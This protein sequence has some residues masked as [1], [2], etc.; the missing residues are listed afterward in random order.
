[1]DVIFCFFK[2]DSTK[3]KQEKLSNS[4]NDNDIK[5]IQHDTSEKASKHSCIKPKKH[6]VVT[7][8][9]V[10]KSVC[11]VMV[12]SAL[13]LNS[14]LNG[15][16]LVHIEYLLH[17]DTQ[18][19]GFAYMTENIGYILGSITCG[20]VMQYC[21]PE[22]LLGFMSLWVAVGIAGLPWAPNVI[23]FGTILVIK[24]VAYG[25]IDSGG[26]AYMLQLWQGHKYQD[27]VFNSFQCTWTLGAFLSPLIVLPFLSDLPHQEVYQNSSALWNNTLT[28]NQTDALS[29]SSSYKE[30][31]VTTHHQLT[32]V[33]YAYITVATLNF[34]PFLLF[35]IVFC[36]DKSGLNHKPNTPGYH[37]TSQKDRNEENPH[38]LNSSNESSQSL[39]QNHQQQQHQKQN[40]RKRLQIVIMTLLAFIILFETWMNYNFNTF[41]SAFVITRLQWDTAKGPLVTSVSRCG[42]LFGQIVGIPISARLQPRTMLLCNIS[43]TTLAFCLMFLAVVTGKAVLLWISVGMAGIFMSTIFGCVLLWGSHF[44]KVTP[45][46]GSLF[47]I[48]AAVGM[49]SSAAITGYL[50]D[51]ISPM[52]LIYIGIISAFL[53]IILFLSVV[54]MERLCKIG[55]RTNEENSNETDN[56]NQDSTVFRT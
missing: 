7:T 53:L 34:L 50:F 36:L 44:V 20:F 5:K 17:T 25:F 28:V 43:M 8:N 9:R 35:G 33:R 22:L 1:M 52:W 45:L 11:I 37:L 26:Q 18:G 12:N 19:M 16:T 21:N 51:N 38:D 14:G 49:M 24:N 10:F 6:P 2:K 39:S 47:M 40:L 23:I 41:I 54:L 32:K 13:G 42:E 56:D 30:N 4:K 29:N 3:T 31:Q 48:A 15:P 46:Y 55:Q 27:P